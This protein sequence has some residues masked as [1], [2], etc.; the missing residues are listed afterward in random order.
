MTSASTAATPATTSKRAPNA[1]APALGDGERERLDTAVD[2]LQIG[3]RTWAAL[4]VAQRAT[5]LR[6]VRTSVAATAE[7]WANTAAA[8]KALDAGHPLRGEE[9]LSGPYS[10]LGAL[11]AYIETLSR[12]ARGSTRSTGSR[13]TAPP[14]G[15]P[16]CTPS[17]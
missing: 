13:S 16:G 3:A 4:T 17:P 15:A 5:L 8:S 14:A 10:V 11:D 6:A 9:W 2:A 1:E 12:L 7:D